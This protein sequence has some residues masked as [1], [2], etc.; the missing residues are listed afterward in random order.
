MDM[1]G[2]ARAFFEACEAGQGWEA[3]SPYRL[4]HATFAAQS[5]PLA[6]IVTLEPNADW[7]RGLLTVLTD[8]QYDLKSFAVDEQRRSVCA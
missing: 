4:P 1:A 2:K 5:E 7:M 8:G 6:G 3:C